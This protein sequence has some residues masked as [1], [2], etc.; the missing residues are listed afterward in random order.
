MQESYIGGGM[1]AE[2]FVLFFMTDLFD[3]GAD[4]RLRDLKTCLEIVLIDFVDE[5]SLTYLDVAKES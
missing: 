5:I 4:Y 2:P 1:S 3:E